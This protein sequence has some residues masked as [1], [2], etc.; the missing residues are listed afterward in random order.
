[1]QNFLYF[2]QRVL[3]GINLVGCQIIIKNIRLVITLK[4]TFISLLLF[5]LVISLAIL[6]DMIQGL[7]FNEILHSFIKIGQQISGEDYVILLI[8]FLPVIFS[9]VFNYIKKQPL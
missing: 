1:M 4:R 9:K 2:P 6:M 7:G 3:S 5:F 8:F